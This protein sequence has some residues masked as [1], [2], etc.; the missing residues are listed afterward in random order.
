MRLF[1]LACLIL[2]SAALLGLITGLFTDNPGLWQ[3]SAIICS[4]GFA[5][6]I[7]ALPALASYQFTAWILATVVAGL[8]Y[9]HQVIHWGDVDL[10]NKWIR[11]L[12]IQ[13]VMFGMGTQMGLRD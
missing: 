2:S 12:A 4:I 11:L 9:P 1:R 6:G 3:P 8:L 7:G 10:T 5:I 13:T